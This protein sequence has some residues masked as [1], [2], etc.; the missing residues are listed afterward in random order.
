MLLMVKN[1]YQVEL[2][3]SLKTVEEKQY[4]LN[5][6]KYYGWYSTIIDAQF[7]RYGSLDL[8]QYLTNTTLID[9]KLPERYGNVVTNADE[10]ADGTSREEKLL[11]IDIEAKRIAQQIEPAIK[12]YL[13]IIRMSNYIL[14]IGQVQLTIKSPLSDSLLGSTYYSAIVVIGP[15]FFSSLRAKHAS[16]TITN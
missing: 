7:V 6:P 1:I 13:V 4:Y 10:T 12:A 14:V 11:P 15:D 16:Y 8:V 5:K 2:V 3:K 9:N